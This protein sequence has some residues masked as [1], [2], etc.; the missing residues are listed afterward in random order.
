VNLYNENKLQ[1]GLTIPQG[2]RGGDLPLEE[3]N[4]PVKQYS[5]S[6]SIAINADTL[7]FDSIYA[8]DHLIPF[9]TDDMNKNIFDC[10]TLLSAATAITKRIK[11]GQIVTC[12]SY[13]N[14]SLLAK[15]ISTLDVIS[16]GRIELGI[17][18]GWYEQEYK[19]YGYDF[20]SYMTR[21]GQLDESLSIIKDMWGEEVASFEGKYYW[22]RDAI[23]N[24]KPI[25]KPHPV[26][27]VG[28]SG[29]KHLLKVVAKHAD[30]Y[31]LFFGSPDEMR[32]KIYVLKEYCKSFDSGRRKN[33]YN[34]IQY[35]VVLPCII[36]ESEE[37]VN[38]IIM[39]YKRKDR[40][41]DQYVKYLVGG[42]TSGTPE[43]ILK[44]IYEY[45]D[46]GVTHFI[47]H[48]IGLNTRSL[49]LF[50]SKVI[51]KV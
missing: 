13:R 37:E 35:S 1:F 25:Q 21:I 20:P 17:G 28:G 3:E 34:K 47:F 11:I 15:T 12:N 10:F 48:F 46:I 2:W 42:I 32:R 33:F 14:P 4:N 27:M 18:A 7:G 40:T 19:A 45:L 8:Y 38:Q 41:A 6:K 29:E 9:H 5:F 36:R 30:R 51:K 50:D 22:I 23:C 16:D 31:N 43:T 26:I 44:G 49:N 39:L 24:P